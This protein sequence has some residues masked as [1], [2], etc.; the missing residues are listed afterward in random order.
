MQPRS[1]IM[2][3]VRSESFAG[4]WIG[5]D[6]GSSRRDYWYDKLMLMFDRCGATA[7]S[8]RDVRIVQRTDRCLLV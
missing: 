4:E 5:V 7:R 2:E 6:S 8:A 3:M 1:V